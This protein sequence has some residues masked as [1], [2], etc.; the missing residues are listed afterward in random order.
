LADPR[1]AT[2][3][4]GASGAPDPAAIA[5]ASCRH[6]RVGKIACLSVVAWA[7]RTRRFCPR[8]PCNAAPLPT[9]RFL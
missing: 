4:A 2:G 9:L 1:T 7:R 5:G 6:H 3:R 8:G